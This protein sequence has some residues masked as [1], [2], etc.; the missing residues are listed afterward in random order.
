MARTPLTSSIERAVAEVAA[1]GRGAEYFARGSSSSRRGSRQPASPRTV[2][3]R[4]RRAARSNPP[5]RRRRRRPRRPDVRVPPEAG[6]ATSPRSTRR[7]P[8]RR[9][10]LDRTRVFAEGQIDEHGGELID[11]GHTQIR[12]LA[13]ELGL[14]PRQPPPA[15]PN[16]TELLAYFDGAPYTYAEVDRRHQAGLA[17][18]PLGRLRGELPDALRQLHAARAGARPHVDRRLDRRSDPG[19]RSSSTSR[20]APGRRLQHRVRRG[21]AP[22]RARSTSSTCSATRARA[23]SASSA[24]RTR[25][26]TCAAATTRSRP[27]WR[28]RSRAR[29]RPAPS[30]SRSSGRRRR[31]TRSRSGSGSNER[32]GRRQGRARAAVLDPPALGRRLAGRASRRASGQAIGEQGMGTNSK[33]HLQFTPPALGR[34]RVERRDVTPTRGYQSTLGGLPRPARARPGSSSTTR[35]A[36]SARASAPGR[37]DQRAEQ[38]LAQI[39]P[40]LPGLSRALERA[41]DGGLLGRLPVDARLVLLLEGRPVHAFAG[42]EE[43]AG[44]QRPL[45]RRAHLDRL[46]GLPERRRRDGRAGRRRGD[47]RPRLGSS[48]HLTDDL[49]DVSV[50]H[51]VRAADTLAVEARRWAPDSGGGE[52][53]RELVVDR[54]RDVLDGRAGMERERLRVVLATMSQ[55]D[56]TRPVRPQIASRRRS[57]LSSSST[58]TGTRRPRDAAAAV[59]SSSSIFVAARSDGRSMPAAS[60]SART[61]PNSSRER[62]PRGRTRSRPRFAARRG[63][64]ALRPGPRS[65]PR[66]APGSRRAARG[67]RRSGSAPATG[68]VVVNA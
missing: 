51:D 65:R 58:E 68:R 8:R 67:R 39:E 38:F 56:A 62:S 32:R 66:S 25:S 42:V 41:G 2:T 46:P 4:R 18:D 35:A 60:T 9:P 14:E 50:E 55:V 24:S 28:P 5:H 1:A 49:D 54:V 17:E 43:P 15:E 59:A 30:S 61:T 21:V 26:T 64:R 6:R 22:S 13:Q 33:L 10:L 47:R 63:V 29:S 7:R 40:V 31:A 20:P 45:L 44:G 36:T 23:S 34:P 16:G 19:R 11:Q 52:A 37:R 57:R 27:G 48:S 53:L 3:S 12:S